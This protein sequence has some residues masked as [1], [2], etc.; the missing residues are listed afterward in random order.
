ML[1]S[2]IGQLRFSRLQYTTAEEQTAFPEWYAAQPNNT[3]H[4]CVLV[5]SGGCFMLIGYRY[6]EKYG[7]FLRY[8]YSNP[9]TLQK[10]CNISNGVFSF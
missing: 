1:A 9:G 4:L 10:Y 8:S 5:R 6:T 2:G 7:A 3:L